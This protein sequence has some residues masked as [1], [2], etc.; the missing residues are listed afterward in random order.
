MDN[1]FFSSDKILLFSTGWLYLQCSS[2]WTWI[3][4]KAFWLRFLSARLRYMSHHTL[5]HLSTKDTGGTGTQF[6]VMPYTEGK[7]GEGK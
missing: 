6:Y 1:N 7:G 2:V 3:S 4:E 5:M